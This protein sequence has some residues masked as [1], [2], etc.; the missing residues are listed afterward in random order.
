VLDRLAVVAATLGDDR[1]EVTREH[2]LFTSLV[3]A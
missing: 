2:F 3:A 1:V